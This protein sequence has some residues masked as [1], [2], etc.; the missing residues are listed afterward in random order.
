MILNIVAETQQEVHQYMTLEHLH[1]IG[2]Y[3]MLTP[4][5]QRNKFPNIKLHFGRTIV[6]KAMCGVLP[7]SSL[8]GA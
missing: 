7:P 3:Q 2:K 8:L 5:V 6:F 1:K 4:I